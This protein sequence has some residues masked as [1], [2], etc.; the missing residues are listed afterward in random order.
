[1]R[2]EA[3]ADCRASSHGVRLLA[4]HG[5]R[6]D[7]CQPGKDIEQ[8]DVLDPERAGVERQ[9]GHHGRHRKSRA[10]VEP[11]CKQDT[12]VKQSA[13][14]GL[15]DRVRCGPSVGSCSRQAQSDRQPEKR[16]R[17]REQEHEREAAA[18]VDQ[19]QP[20]GREDDGSTCSRARV[21]AGGLAPALH[22][23]RHR[24]RGVAADIET[25]PAQPAHDAAGEYHHQQ[26]HEEQK[27]ANGEQDQAD[28]Q[29]A[30]G[31]PP[32]RDVA[33]KRPNGEAGHGESKER[34]AGE[35]S[36]AAQIIDIE[37]DHRRQYPLIGITEE[38]RDAQQVERPRKEG[39]RRAHG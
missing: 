22:R 8:A 31:V 18:P 34:Q 15:G 16:E 19:P 24:Q 12:P 21:V 6:D 20:Q 17:C 13:G 3:K 30:R 4:K 2:A 7:A 10:K 36:G 14:P 26:R 35:K 9:E 32:V 11:R 27:T 33:H 25:G 5:P 1:M 37:R 38:H 39:R 28:G 29:H 23:R